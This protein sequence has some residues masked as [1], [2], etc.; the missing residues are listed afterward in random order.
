MPNHSA[1]SHLVLPYNPVKNSSK[2]HHA[3]FYLSILLNER[4][5]QT[6]TL[7]YESFTGF[8]TKLCCLRMATFNHVI[9]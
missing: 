9:L 7:I 3:D 8:V 6:H 5:M 4:K 2:I 1:W